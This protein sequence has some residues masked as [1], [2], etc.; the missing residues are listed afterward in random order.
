MP[1]KGDL[2]SLDPLTIKLSDKEV[3]DALLAAT[4]GTAISAGLGVLGLGKVF[5]WK[6]RLDDA[7]RE[8]QLN[9]VLRQFAQQ[10]ASVDDAVARLQILTGT[11]E[12]Q[13]LFR[14]VI[15][16]LESGESDPDWTALLATILKNISDEKIAAQFRQ[17]EF[18]LSQID[19]LSPQ[20]L[21]VLSKY[22]IWKD[23]L[24]SGTTTTSKQTMAGDWDSQISNFLARRIDVADSSAILRIGHT[25][26]ELE[27]SGMV[28]LSG[29]YVKLTIIGAELYRII[30]T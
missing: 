14:K 12:G 19:K 24:I 5:E 28:L 3:K 10:F 7:L 11:R 20:S 30:G 8:Q 25:F 4:K 16:I 23:A 9:N 17:Y 1:D 29:S 27:S 21:V 26:K 2:Q 6:E 15:Q 18:L 13:V 22:N